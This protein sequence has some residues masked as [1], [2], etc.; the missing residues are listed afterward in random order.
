[1]LLTQAQRK[2]PQNNWVYLDLARLM[3][4]EGD[5]TQA[6][7]LILQL[8]RRQTRD[9][10][11]IAALFYVEQK[12]WD[13]VFTLLNSQPQQNEAEKALLERARFYRQ[14]TQAERY[15]KTGNLVAMRNTLRPLINQVADY[16]NDVGELAEKL[17]NSGAQDEALQLIE[18]DLAK[19]TKGSV[20][21][22]A[23][24]INVFNALGR[25]A[26]AS[27]LINDPALQQQTPAAEKQRLAILTNVAQADSLREK[28]EIKAA[29]QTLVT[30][31]KVS[32]DDPDLLMALSR[33]YLAQSM[34]E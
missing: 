1:Q 32:P 25:Y 12:Q 22:Y 21:N 16:P 2:N 9:A 14:L 30:S 17:V 28:G 26:Q 4:A 31:L 11:Y 3:I 34:P 19:G 7:Q 24:H 29:Y 15:Y 18:N 27:S 5:K 33:V 20:G 8:E 10:N 13:K 6:E 23:G